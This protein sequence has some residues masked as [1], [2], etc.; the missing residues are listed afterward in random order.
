MDMKIALAG[1]PNCGNTTLFN[2]LTGSHQEVGNW[3][4]VTGDKKTGVF[5]HKNEEIEL[6]D[7]PGIYSI[8]PSSSSGEDE[9][10]ARDYILTGEAE[11]IINIVDASNLE[12]NL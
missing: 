12:R 10:V 3:P 1:N 4:G 6:V 5:S 9:R 11:A 7:L 2:E 8:T